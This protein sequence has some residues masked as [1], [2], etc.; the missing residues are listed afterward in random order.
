MGDSTTSMLA[1]AA[2]GTSP[3]GHTR[4]YIHTVHERYKWHAVS[5]YRMAGLITHLATYLLVLMQY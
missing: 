3:E 1:E 2:F 4:E 5:Q